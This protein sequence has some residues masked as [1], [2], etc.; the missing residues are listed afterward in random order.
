MAKVNLHKM[1]PSLTTH[2]AQLALYTI[3]G[4][5]TRG[6]PS[7]LLNIMQHDVIEHLAEAPPGEY[8]QDPHR[9]YIQMQRNIGTCLLDQYLAENPLSMGDFG[10]ESEAARTA[11][12]GSQQVIL[13]GIVIESPESVVEHLERFEFPRLENETASFDEAA[14][15]SSI[16]A[17]ETLTQEK[18]G[19]DIL[20]SP[21]GCAAFPTLGYGVYGYVP[22]F[23]AFGLYPDVIEQH[24]ERQAD[25]ALRIN[26]ATAQAYRTANLPPL[27]RLDHDMADSRGTLVSLKSL[28]RMWFPHF[29]R[30]LAP[31]LEAGVRL[32]WHCD[33]NLMEMI[34]PLIESG[35]SGFQGFQYEDGMD[36]SRICRMKDRNGRDLLIIAGVSV[37]RTLPFGTPG[38]VRREMQW[39]VATGPRTGLILGASSSIT[40]GTPL[41]NIQT[42]VEGLKYYQ[43]YG[44]G[45]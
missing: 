42:L 39:L 44:R 40:P 24:F 25:L 8:R 36:Y 11:T 4:Q 18:L 22:Y 6:I 16:L 20:K 21:Y 37:T 33:G 45:K 31:L 30:C 38:D 14:Y 35:I 32:I 3:Y 26:R 2:R 19:R 5:P 7:W 15:T 23:S 43:V 12:T 13:D 1:T 17:E 10:F 9:V 28:E 41:E 27:Y 34:P 29:S